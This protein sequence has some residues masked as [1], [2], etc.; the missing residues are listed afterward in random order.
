MSHIPVSV[1]VAAGGSPDDF[2]ACLESLRPSL[3]LRDE[4]VCVMPRRDALTIA[5][6][7][8]ADLPYE[9]LAAQGRIV[10]AQSSLVAHVASPQ[11]GLRLPDPPDDA[12]LLSAS[13]IVKDEEDVLE[14]CL[15][16]L[17]P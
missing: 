2:D 12:P 4:V 7:P 17:K 14:R 8:T 15:I 16:A 5:G 11:C 13:L 1:I 9:E 6:G 3:G 10:I